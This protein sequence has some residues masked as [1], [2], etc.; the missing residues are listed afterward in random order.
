MSVA[1]TDP[2]ES[3]ESSLVFDRAQD[4]IRLTE[5]VPI[6][7]DLCAIVSNFWDRRKS[8]NDIIE[9]LVKKI[10]KGEQLNEGEQKDLA[11]YGPLADRLSLYH[12]DYNKDIPQPRLDIILQAVSNVRYL[13]IYCRTSSDESNDRIIESVLRRYG[14]QLISLEM[15]HADRRQYSHIS[16]HARQIR[17]LRIQSQNAAQEDIED[18]LEH[19]QQLRV[20]ELL[21]MTVSPLAKS[22]LFALP[23]LEALRFSIRKSIPNLTDADCKSIAA[24]PQLRALSF[25]SDESFNLQR[26][27]SVFDRHRMTHLSLYGSSVTDA[28]VA[29]LPRRFPGLIQVHFA[30]MYGKMIRTLLTIPTLRELIMHQCYY[31]HVSDADKEQIKA[32]NIKVTFDDI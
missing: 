25:N 22:R 31:M 5:V 10:I 24:C 29:E 27:I 19:C 4:A 23:H 18:I 15:N 26:I 17:V 11:T 13:D 3:Y 28:L 20:V 8:A 32:R 2:W 16:A 6:P 7:K 12:S 1:A 30:A 9:A 21:W 14:P